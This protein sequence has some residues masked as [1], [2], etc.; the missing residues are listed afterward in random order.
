[1]FSL[2]DQGFFS[3]WYDFFLHFGYT[4]FAFL[5]HRDEIH[6]SDWDFIRNHLLTPKRTLLLEKIWVQVF[7]PKIICEYKAS[8]VQDFNPKFNLIF[9]V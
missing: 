4:Y 3:I 6:H 9:P 1:M 5:N 2:Q 7:N 8:L